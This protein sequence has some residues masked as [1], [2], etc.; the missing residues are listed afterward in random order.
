LTVKPQL[1]FVGFLIFL[2]KWLHV[3]APIRP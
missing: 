2:S 1:V 3:S